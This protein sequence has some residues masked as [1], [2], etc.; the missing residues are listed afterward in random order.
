MALS[1]QIIIAKVGPEFQIAG[2]LGLRLVQYISE[3]NEPMHMHFSVMCGVIL[4]IY[5]M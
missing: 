2:L 1:P 3:L 4:V 5:L